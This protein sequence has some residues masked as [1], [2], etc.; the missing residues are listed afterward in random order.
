VSKNLEGFTLPELEALSED[1]RVDKI[2]I[3]LHKY[4][5]FLT[6]Y[7]KPGRGTSKTKS[8]EQLEPSTIMN[9]CF[10]LISAV[11]FSDRFPG[12]YI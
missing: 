3:A 9:Y 2:K 4:V 8:K 6:N 5:D 12:C 10:K 11:S 1:E 7:H